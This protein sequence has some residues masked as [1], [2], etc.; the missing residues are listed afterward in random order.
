MKLLTHARWLIISFLVFTY[1][2]KS[3]FILYHNDGER[4]LVANH[5]D[6]FANDAAIKINPPTSQNYG[7]L[8]FTFLSEGWAQGGMNEKGLFFDGAFT[9]FQTIDFENDKVSF[10]GHIWQEV[11]DKCATV[12]EALNLLQKYKLPDL[13][14]SHI[15]LADPEKAVL[16]GVN[17]G[18]LAIAPWNGSFLLQTNFNPWHPELSDKP[19]CQR[20]DLGLQVLKSQTNT[21]QANLLSILKQTHQDS[22]TV[23]SNI[24]DLRNKSVITYYNRN[25]EQPVET[26]LTDLFK[27][28][29]KMIS[30]AD[31]KDH[32]NLE[33]ALVEDGKVTVSGLLLDAETK[34]PIPYANIGIKGK[35]AGTL[36][37]PDGTFQIRIS[38]DLQDDTL[39]FSSIGYKQMAFSVK[40]IPD[41]TL[42]LQKNVQLLDNVTIKAKKNTKVA[43]LGWMKGD[44]GILPFDTVAGGGAVAML[45][46]APE[47]PFFVSQVMIRLLYNSKDTTKLRLHFYEITVDSLPGKEILSKEIIL[48]EN[49]RFGWMRFDMK[50]YNITIPYKSFFMAFEWIDDRKTRRLMREGLLKWDRWKQKQYEQGERKVELIK[51]KSGVRYKYHGNMMHWP[52][53]ENLPPWT[54][55]MVETGKHKKTSHL[56]TYQRKTS[57]SQWQEKQATLNAVL[58]LRY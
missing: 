24:Y 35:S 57:F 37:D 30:L 5:E 14:E 2:A 7:S 49:K 26:K 56:R 25:F 39:F 9:P 19:S 43:R 13:E 18:K 3:C 34:T 10:S 32:K 48:E 6:W 45:M 50:P 8:T 53:F 21:T 12:D 11:L 54:G 22:L 44:D 33:E 42:Y 41:T 46:Q 40:E 47:A 1:E 16:L 52:G 38:R 58:V 55:L 27:Y 17:N 29:S 51:T 15:V 31:L 28:G 23:Y 4:T 36:T 20:Y